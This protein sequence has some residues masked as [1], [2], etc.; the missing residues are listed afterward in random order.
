MSEL[1]SIDTFEAKSQGP[2]KVPNEMAV[3][4]LGILSLVFC[5]AYGIVGLILGIIAL[6]MHKKDKELYNSNPRAYE[7]SF[8]NSKAGRICGLIGVIL[9]SIYMI[10][11]FMFIFMMFYYGA[12]HNSYRY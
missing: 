8:K 6:V 4:I 9:S 10:A 7:A 5:F 3:L 12:N 11:I 2:K 1:E